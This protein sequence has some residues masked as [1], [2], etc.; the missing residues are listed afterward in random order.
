MQLQKLI[1]EIFRIY[2]SKEIHD[3]DQSIQPGH[4]LVNMV[5]K[6]T[7]SSVLI[8]HEICINTGLRQRKT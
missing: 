3:L 2:V 7:L 8:F 4:L 6:V 1:R 5:L